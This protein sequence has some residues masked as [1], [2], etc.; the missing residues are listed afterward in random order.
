MGVGGGNGWVGTELVD[1]VFAA[2]AVLDEDG[3]ADLFLF[4]DAAEAFGHDYEF[5][6]GDVVFLD[7]F[8]DDF[9]G[10]A[11]GVDVCGV[12]LFMVRGAD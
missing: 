6:A 10:G 9:F 8:A 4:A 1:V 11:V 3:A 5:L 2:V 12:P 7:G